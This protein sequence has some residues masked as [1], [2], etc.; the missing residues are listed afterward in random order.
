MQLWQYRL[1]VT[2]RL[3]YIKFY[4]YQL[5]HLFLSYTKIT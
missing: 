3:L 4:L 1:L 5:M 2:A